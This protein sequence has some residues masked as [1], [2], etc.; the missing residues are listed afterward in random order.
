MDFPRIHPA[1]TGK[2]VRFCFCATLSGPIT[3]GAAK[4]D[5]ATGAIVGRIEFPPG[6]FGSGDPVFVPA[7]PAQSAWSASQQRGAGA[8][9]GEED[10]G[11]LLTYVTD[12][13]K[14]N[15]AEV[16]PHACERER[17]KMR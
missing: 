3:T 7:G 11:Y 2:P 16:R 17:E 13:T 8:E 15:A 1:L 14:G 6:C 5:V 10:E 9:E 4:I 12:E